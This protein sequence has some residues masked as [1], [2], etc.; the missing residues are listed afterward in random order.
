[1]NLVF[2]TGSDVFFKNRIGI[3]LFF[4]NVSGSATLSGAY[5]SPEST[6]FVSIFYVLKEKKYEKFEF[7]SYFELL[8]LFF[9]KKWKKIP[10]LRL[11]LGLSLK[12]FGSRTLKRSK[13]FIIHLIDK[14]ELFF[15]TW[16]WIFP[17]KPH[18]SSQCWL[19][20][21]FWQIPFYFTLFL[22]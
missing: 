7:F 9:G 5:I 22:W 2:Q 6:N 10:I 4:K 3:W 11:K 19:Q 21:S 18:I 20:G 8:W 16:F 15:L 1:M 13:N 17:Y 14:L 12:S